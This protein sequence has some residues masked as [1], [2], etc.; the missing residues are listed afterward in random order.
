MVC[1][2][3]LERGSTIP[4][5]WAKNPYERWAC[6]SHVE[7]REKANEKCTHVSCLVEEKDQRQDLQN[8][9]LGRR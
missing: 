3:G 9:S 5:Y 2:S 1:G 4:H 8:A 6:P 7:R